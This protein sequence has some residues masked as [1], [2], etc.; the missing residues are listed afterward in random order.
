MSYATRYSISI[1]SWGWMD[2][3]TAQVGW[4]CSL[5]GTSSERPGALMNWRAYVKLSHVGLKFASFGSAEVSTRTAFVRG[6]VLS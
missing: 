3:Q 2:V 6:L 4:M 5:F 1:S